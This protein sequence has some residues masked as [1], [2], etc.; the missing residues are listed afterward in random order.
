MASLNDARAIVESGVPN[1]DWGKV[2][3]VCEKWDKFGL[4]Y[5]PSSSVQAG[6][7]SPKGR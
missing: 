2:I 4:G 7:A 6:L 5:Q 1:E 3:E